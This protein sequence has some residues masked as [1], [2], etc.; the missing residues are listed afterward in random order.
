MLNAIELSPESATP[1]RDDSSIL[2]SSLGETMQIA[3]TKAGEM[4][5][6]ARIHRNRWFERI[7]RRVYF[8][9]GRG[10]MDARS[11]GNRKWRDCE[12][13]G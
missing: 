10:G 5:I 1:N 9:A 11:D 7:L 12:C 4:A 6:F 13:Q 3:K 8:A 2:K